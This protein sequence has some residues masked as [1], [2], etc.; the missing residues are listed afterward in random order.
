MVVNAVVICGESGTG[1][2]FA[3]RR[4]AT[5]VIALDSFYLAP[6][7]EMPTWAGR[8]D[9][10]A[11]E[12]YDLSAAIAAV[13]ALCS[14]GTA[15]LPEYDL[16]T[17]RPTGRT[18][19]VTRLGDSAI[20]EGIFGADVARGLRSSGLEVDLYLL[21]YQP[22]ALVAQRVRRD[23]AEKRLPP[24]FALARSARLLKGGRGYRKRALRAGARPIHRKDL[25][26]ILGD[27]TPKGES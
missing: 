20:A 11:V 13:L 17:D 22:L 18:R 27:M 6:T 23:L 24:W 3:T 1:K 25:E 2:S 5:G 19:R 15:D 4:L 12:T 10:E 8:V 16:S 9:W 14:E 7:T 21:K 26:S